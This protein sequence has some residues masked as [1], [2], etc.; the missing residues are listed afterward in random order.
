MALHLPLFHLTL[1]D[2]QSSLRIVNDPKWPVKNL[3]NFTPYKS[4]IRA[5]TSDLQPDQL[6]PFVV[7]TH[8]LSRQLYNTLVEPVNMRVQHEYTSYTVTIDTYI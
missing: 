4:S 7:H 6:S 3:P 2:L 1:A 8:T 5:T